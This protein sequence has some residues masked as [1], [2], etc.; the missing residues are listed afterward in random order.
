MPTFENPEALQ[1]PRLFRASIRYPLLF[2]ETRSPFRAANAASLEQVLPQERLSP[3]EIDRQHPG[4]HD[5]LDAQE[6]RLAVEFLGRVG[7]AVAVPALEIASVRDRPVY[8]ERRLLE[9]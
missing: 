1:A 8:G 4:L 7:P 9:N 6:Q 2:M 3:P 5:L